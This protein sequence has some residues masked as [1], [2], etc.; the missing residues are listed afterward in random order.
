MADVAIA[1]SEIATRK[2]ETLLLRMV[3]GSF[4]VETTKQNA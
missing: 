3:V 1:K 4:D 2:L